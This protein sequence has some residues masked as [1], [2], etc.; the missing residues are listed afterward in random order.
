MTAFGSSLPDLNEHD[1]LPSDHLQELACVELRQLAPFR[2]PPSF[3]ELGVG[4]P[5]LQT[6]VLI[7]DQRA[8]HVG[9]V[10]AVGVIDPF[11][12]KTHSLFFPL[13]LFFSTLEMVGYREA[14]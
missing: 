8:S 11:S 9:V 12:S 10:G 5:K 7:N 14:G 4:H 2:I 6:V 13:A 3:E 1:R